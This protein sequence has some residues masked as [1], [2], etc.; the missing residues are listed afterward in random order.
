MV[1]EAPSSSSHASGDTVGTR[2]PIVPEGDRFDQHKLVVSEIA[3]ITRTHLNEGKPSWKK[4]SKEQRD[5]FFDL[6]KF[7]WP[8]EH[9]V[10]VRRNFEK[11]SAAKMSQLMQ[12]VRRDLEYRPK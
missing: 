4:L 3:H 9:K 2:I 10:T 6:F 1:V 8:P 11:R 7:T 5:S 12:D